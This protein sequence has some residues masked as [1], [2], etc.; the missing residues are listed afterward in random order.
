MDDLKIV[1]PLNAI[2]RANKIINDFKVPG[3]TLL[4]SDCYGVYI[5]A[6]RLGAPYKKTIS[7][8]FICSKC[9]KR[10]NYDI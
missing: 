9:K 1:D 6:K 5:T 4:K 2:A 3:Y 10:C 8:A 7:F